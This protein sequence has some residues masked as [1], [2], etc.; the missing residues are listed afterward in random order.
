MQLTTARG[1]AS[2]GT[3]GGPGGSLSLAR[4]QQHDANTMIASRREVINMGQDN[5]IET[6]N[7]GQ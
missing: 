5:Y 3:A 4:Y 2:S 6:V 7:S 1:A